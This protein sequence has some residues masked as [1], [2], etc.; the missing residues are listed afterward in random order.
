LCASKACSNEPWGATTFPDKA[1]AEPVNPSMSVL[2]M[3]SQQVAR[4]YV[5]VLG[6][7]D[8]RYVLRTYPG[9]R[10]FRMGPKTKSQKHV[11]RYAVNS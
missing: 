6:K 4:N 5:Q 10:Y 7:T 1:S 8:Y 3:T 2:L 11:T 9:T